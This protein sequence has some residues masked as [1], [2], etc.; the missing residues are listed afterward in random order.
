MLSSLFLQHLS[1]LVQVCMGSVVDLLVPAGAPFPLTQMPWRKSLSACRVDY[2]ATVL[3]VGFGM[4]CYGQVCA[5]WAA[6]FSFFS[7]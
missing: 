1:A 6:R 7:Y 4:V 2:Y 3:K 5:A